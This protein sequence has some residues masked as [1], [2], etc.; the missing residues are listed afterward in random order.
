MKRTVPTLL[1]VVLL[2]GMLVS[3][4]A[5]TAMSAQADRTPESALMID[6]ILSPRQLGLLAGGFGP[7]LSDLY[8]V[9]A[10][11][12]AGEALDSPRGTVRLYQ[13][14]ERV[15][16]LDPQFEPAYQ[17]GALLLSVRAGRPDLGDK[18][19]H[20]AER[21]FPQNWEY[22]FYLGFNRFYYEADFLAAAD[23][24]D[25][26]ARLPGAPDYF[27]ALATRFRDQQHNQDVARDLLQR[28][29]KISD[30]PVIKQRLERR[31]M[32][33]QVPS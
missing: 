10:I 12:T 19:L 6:P 23:H 17:Y 22:P 30:D 2:V 8:W 21:Q 25:R 24:F 18:L 1:T 9:R 32:E 15:V 11:S 29:I 4:G 26:A 20:A 14:L 33:L 16:A 27:A 7:A 28:L 5:L 13:L 3:A 31:L